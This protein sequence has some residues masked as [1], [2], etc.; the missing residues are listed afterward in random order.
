MDF[1][2]AQAAAWQNKTAKGFNTTD[3][4]LECMFLVR[5]LA[6]AFTAWREG[7]GDAGEELADVVIF[8]FGLAGILG[9]DL[10]AAVAAKLKVNEQRTY[11]QL[12]NGTLVKTSPCG[13]RADAQR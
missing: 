3:V 4:P 12:P 6:E 1:A 7:R 5:E 9:V 10:G 11:G 13:E 2:T 8:A